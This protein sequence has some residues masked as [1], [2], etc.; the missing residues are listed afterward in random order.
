MVNYIVCRIWPQLSE[1]L[2]LVLKH[3]LVDDKQNVG[4]PEFEIALEAS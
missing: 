2:C 4:I 3:G 1:T